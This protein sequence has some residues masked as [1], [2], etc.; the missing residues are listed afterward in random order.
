MPKRIPITEEEFVQLAKTC[1]TDEIV[2]LKGVSKA[3]V[4]EKQSIYNVLTMRTCASCGAKFSPEGMER[5]C[6]TCRDPEAKKEKYK[7]SRLR[8]GKRKASN[9]F[10]IE[11]EMRLQGKCYADYQKAQTIAEFAR[12]EI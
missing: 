5:N 10:A 7:Q 1:T 3:W 6:P 4:Q 2:A 12:V 9:A 11:G 8:K